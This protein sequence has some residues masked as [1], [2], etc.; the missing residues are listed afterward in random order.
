[1]EKIIKEEKKSVFSRSFSKSKKVSISYGI[2][3]ALAVCYLVLFEFSFSVFLSALAFVFFA[4]LDIQMYGKRC[5]LMW[6]L[7]MFGL[8]GLIASLVHFTTSE[9]CTIYFI[10]VGLAFIICSFLQNYMDKILDFIEDCET[11]LH[12]SNFPSIIA[13]FL[14]VLCVG[15]SDLIRHNMARDEFRMKKEKFIPIKFLSQEIHSGHTYYFFEAKGKVCFMNP[16]SFPE[17][18]QTNKTF[19][20]KIILG[21]YSTDFGA[22]EIKKIELEQ[23]K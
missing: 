16:N 3:I 5:N 13:T 12:D 18:R 17:I 10:G 8:F 19:R 21:F 23:N 1:M 15:S 11:D 2:S 14:F 6:L 9:G 22:Y 7:F 4:W 20:A